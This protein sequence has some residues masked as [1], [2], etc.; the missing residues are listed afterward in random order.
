MS[1]LVKKLKSSSADLFK[2]SQSKVTLWRKC[3]KAYQYQHEEQIERR[4]KPR[5][6]KFGTIVHKIL[7]ADARG[8]DPFSEL[9]KI[10][11]DN[12]QMFREHREIYGDMITDIRYIMTAYYEYWNKTPIHLLPHKNGKIITYAE[13]PYEIEFKGFLL[14]GK[15]DGVAKS[16]KMN[17]LLERKTHKTF[18]N[19]DHRWRN[20]QSAVYIRIIEMLGWWPNI[21]GTM[22]DYIRSKPP[23]RPMILKNGSVSTRELDSLPQVV[24][25]T[26]E[27][28]GVK[29]P[30]ELI[31]QQQTK[32]NTWFSRV[33]TPIKKPVVDKLF[34][35]YIETGKQMRDLQGVKDRPRTIGRHCEWCQFEQLCRA[36]MQGSDEE[37]IKQHEYTRSDYEEADE[38][39]TED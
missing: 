16:K 25:D 34:R 23:T 7:D 22:W 14:K 27:D 20:L 19:T 31:A 32:L 15:I 35:D 1:K 4:A 29:V 13:H 8:E 37:F 3:Q 33:Y 6:L 26:L 17:W 11:K 39:A 10:A 24:I 12:K 28:E 36:A 9:D 38:E 21:E 30:H 5:P 18:P 2:I